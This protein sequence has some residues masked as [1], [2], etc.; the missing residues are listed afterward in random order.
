MIIIDKDLCTGCGICIPYC[1]VKALNLDEENN[2]VV[3]NASRCTDCWGCIGNKVCPQEAIK[4]GPQENFRDIFRHYM[5]DPNA[6]TGTGLKGRGT[7]EA[8]TNDVTGRFKR[9]RVGFA[10]DMGRPGVGVYLRDVEKV[11]KT[12]VGAG[13]ALED[14]E[15]NPLGAIMNLKTGEIKSEFLDEFLL[16]IIIEGNCDVEN[17]ENALKA[18]K[19]VENEIDTVF[20]LG[21]VLRT[22]DN[23]EVHWP[24]WLEVLDRVGVDRP[25]RGKV[26]VGLGRPLSTD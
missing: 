21:L 14:S 15:K 12:V 23:G 16:S 25:Y 3:V 10:I 5:S 20:S 8:K 26:N 19:K 9:G 22:D 13:L 6:A 2:L 18:L 1:T 7:E 11:A 17:M 24:Q 4:P